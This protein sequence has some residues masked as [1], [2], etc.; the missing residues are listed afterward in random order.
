[1]KLQALGLCIAL[2]A[3]AST[4]LHAQAA[5]P[6]LSSVVGAPFS[7][8]RSQQAA[9]NFVDGNRIDRGGSVRLYPSVEI[10]TSCI[11]TRRPAPFSKAARRQPSR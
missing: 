5:P 7:G 3:L 8:V 11:R 10:G 6:A 9:K 4:V 1:M 2:S